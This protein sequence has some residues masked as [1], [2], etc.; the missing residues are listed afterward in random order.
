MVKKK[1]RIWPVYS[2]IQDKNWP[3]SLPLYWVTL[4]GFLLAVLHKGSPEG[5]EGG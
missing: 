3:L 2:N 4:Y 5:L 1:I